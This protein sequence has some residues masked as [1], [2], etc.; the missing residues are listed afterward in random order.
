MVSEISGVLTAV[1]SSITVANVVLLLASAIGAGITFVL[2]WFGIRK[3]IQVIM[4]AF[5]NGK[6]SV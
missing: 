1:T 3:L 2:A 5:R 4:S 6:L